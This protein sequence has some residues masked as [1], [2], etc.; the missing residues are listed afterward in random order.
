MAYPLP[1]KP[2]IAVLPF[3][4]MSGEAEQ[5]YFVDGL[6][7][8]LITDLSKLSGLFVIARN[9][10][11]GFKGRDVE[12]RE[13]AESLGVRY[14]IEGSV[15]RVGDEVRV[16]VH[17]IDATTG[18]QLWADRYDGGLDDVFGLQDR[19][20][21]LI[22]G[23]LALNLS[24]KEAQEIARGQTNNLDAREAFQKGWEYLVRF[25]RDENESAAAAFRRAI[26]LDPGYGRAYAALG[27]TLYRGC[28]WEWSRPFGINQSQVCDAAWRALSEV[29]Q[30]PSSLAH[31]AATYIDLYSGRHDAAFTEAARAIAFDPNDPEA[32]IG[33]AWAMITT[34]RPQA[35]LEFIR[36]AMRLNPSYPTHYVLARGLALFAAGQ[37]D[38]AARVLADAM[39]DRPGAIELAPPLAA[40]YA[41]QGRRREARELLL[42]WRPDASQEELSDLPF[43]YRI[44]YQWSPASQ[45]AVP[46]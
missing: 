41:L 14:V 13:V 10:V 11:F 43:A 35:G 19:L 34:G 40:T 36:T 26:E 8:D 20:V 30:H 3:R 31:I 17:L 33:M 6:T 16:N 46:A 4:N 23:A 37:L 1:S 2:S 44:A 7:D 32:H 9:S 24:D 28:A 21:R 15:R 27:L 22:G 12:I 29:K 25:D 5:E 18:R 38:D 42:A 39:N 45:A